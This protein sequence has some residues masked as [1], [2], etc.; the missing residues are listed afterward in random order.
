MNR[1]N[2]SPVTGVSGLEHRRSAFIAATADDQA[3]HHS[4]EGGLGQG[5]QDRNNGDDE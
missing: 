5:E 3:V 2:L 1:G 4:H